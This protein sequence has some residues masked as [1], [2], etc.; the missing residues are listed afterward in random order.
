MKTG[1]IRPYLQVYRIVLFI[2]LPLKII[3]LGL[4]KVHFYLMNFRRIYFKNVA[5]YFKRQKNVDLTVFN[6][7]HCRCRRRRHYQRP[8]R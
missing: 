1:V 7:H 6:F 3:R 5:N 4:P 2:L 8:L